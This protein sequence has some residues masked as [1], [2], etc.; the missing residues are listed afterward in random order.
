ML[1]EISNVEEMAQLRNGTHILNRYQLPSYVR[2]RYAR[3]DE[4]KEVVFRL[5]VSG[6]IPYLI[7]DKGTRHR[8]K[9]T[10]FRETDRYFV[11]VDE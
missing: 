11:E 1:K 9:E 10:D 5:K 6:G 7:G 2:Q 3:P 8:V 4:W